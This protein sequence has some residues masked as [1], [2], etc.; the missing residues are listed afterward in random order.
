[1]M[2]QV[3][4]SLL[5]LVLLP[6]H[7]GATTWYVDASVPQSGDGT[8]WESAFKKIQEGIDAASNG[9]TVIVAEGTYVENIQFNGKNIV[10]TGTDPLDPSVVA[11][12]II[13]GNGSGSAVTFEGTED[14]T[15]VLS[16]FTTRNG[17]A[18]YGGGIRGGSPDSAS[19]A[20]IQNNRITGNSAGYGGGLD[21]C[22][23]VIQNNTITDNS[24]V[25]GGG[26]GSCNGTIQNNTITRNSAAHGGG[27]CDSNGRT[28]GNRITGNLASY[29]GGLAYC[30]GTTQNNTITGNRAQYGGALGSCHGTTLGNTITRNSATHEGGGLYYCNG[31]IRNCII[32]ANWAPGSPQ[33]DVSSIPTYSCIEGWTGDSKKRNISGDPRFAGPDAGDFRLLPSSPC[34]DAGLNDPSLPETDMAGMH[35]IMFGGKSLTVDM[36]AYEYYVNEIGVGEE[37]DVTLTWSSLS[38]KTY[39]VRFSEDMVTWELA[40]EGVPSMGDSVTTWLDIGAIPSPGMVKRFYKVE[41]TE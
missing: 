8:S 4:S 18:D 21:R 3:S 2:R 31:P 36:G 17:V 40:A 39:A 24:A 7:A 26:L 11:N 37:G 22:D 5:L 30:K 25:Y 28:L 35:R 32:W 20:T 38:G 27:L 19:R 33:L 10:L 14:E 6:L 15:C 23:G 34:I 9:D 13:D 1:M 41:E 12:T 29:G 16:G